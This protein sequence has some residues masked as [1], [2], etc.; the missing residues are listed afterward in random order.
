MLEILQHALS[1]RLFGVSS[2]LVDLQNG[3]VDL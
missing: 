3:H 2:V 1:H